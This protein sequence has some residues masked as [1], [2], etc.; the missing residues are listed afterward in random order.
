MQQFIVPPWAPTHFAGKRIVSRWPYSMA[1]ELVVPNGET[2]QSFPEAVFLNSTDKPVETW[3][4][5]VDVYPLDDTA[6]PAAPNMITP[7]LAQRFQ[8]ML[9]FFVKIRLG[10]ENLE[11]K[12]TKSNQRLATYLDRNTRC[13]YWSPEPNTISKQQG[14]NVEVDNLAPATF[15]TGTFGGVANEVCGNL[16]I[17]V[18]FIA[19]QLI[20]EAAGDQPAGP[21]TNPP[22][23][24]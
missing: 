20:L 19:F 9:D 7:T 5:R 4:L 10:F 13:R 14:F 8:D 12:I 6:A 23:N 17:V 11:Q 3:G 1:A 21:P 16:L 2:G 18:D 22:R 15:N 24:G